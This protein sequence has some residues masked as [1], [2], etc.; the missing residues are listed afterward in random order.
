MGIGPLGQGRE[1]V[2]TRDTELDSTEGPWGS[3]T[4][5]GQVHAQIN[6]QKVLIFSH[7]LCVS[8]ENVNRIHQ[9]KRGRCKRN[10]SFVSVPDC[11]QLY[12]PGEVG[13][14]VVFEW[15]IFTS[16][17]QRLSFSTKCGCCAT[18]ISVIFMSMCNDIDWDQNR[19]EEVCTHNSA[20]VSAY[21]KSFRTEA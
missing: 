4:V 17:T 16:D 7:I 18:R 5:L 13:R 6:S 1:P 3:C 21:G 8:A 12:V 9:E 20:S 14:T 15:R 19:N 2:P 11:R 10:A